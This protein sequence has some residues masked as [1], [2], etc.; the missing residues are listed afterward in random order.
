MNDRLDHRTAPSDSRGVWLGF[1]LANIGIMGLA[2]LAIV[3]GYVL[4]SR[5]SVTAAPLLLVLGYMVLLPLGLL[6]GYRRIRGRDSE[7][8]PRTPSNKDRR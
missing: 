4:L 6:F 3:W 8:D 7:S 1:G 2:V 5:G